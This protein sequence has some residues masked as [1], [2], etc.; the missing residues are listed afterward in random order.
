ML[1]SYIRMT[2]K[3]ANYNSLR[4]EVDTLRNRYQDLQREANQKKEQ[5]ASLQMLASEV[6]L[7]YGIKQKLEGPADIAGEGP[8]LPT[9]KESLEEYNFLKSAS[10]SKI[11]RNYPR[12]W[13]TNVRPSIWPVAGR[14]L[15]TYGGRTDPFSGEGAFHTGVD[16]SAAVGTPIRAAADGIVMHAEWAGAYGK[17]VVI[18]H[19]NGLTT[20]YAHLSRF[21]VVPGQEIRRGEIVGASGGT[22]RV[23][24]PHLHY[25]VRLGGNPINPY[26]YLSKS[27]VAEVHQKDLPF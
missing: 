27:A 6:S 16:I 7:A 17:M 15:S 18:D 9:Y 3:V 11:Y 8:L 26:T 4:N 10:F 2:W 1:S 20:R 13:Q 5:L 21:D 14:L 25:E 19:G 12:T 24:S 23:T 22:G